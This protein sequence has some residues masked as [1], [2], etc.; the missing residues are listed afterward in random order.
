MRRM[1]KVEKIIGQTY[2]CTRPLQRD[3]EWVYSEVR[4]IMRNVTGELDPN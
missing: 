1:P 4:R 3:A 2:T